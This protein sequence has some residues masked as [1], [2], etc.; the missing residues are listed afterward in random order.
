MESLLDKSADVNASA[1]DERTEVT[2][3]I[4]LCFGNYVNTEEELSVADLLVE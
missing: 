4:E 3:A 1:L 2:R